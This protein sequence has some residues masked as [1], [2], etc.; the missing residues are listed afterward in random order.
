V[1]IKRYELTGYED[2]EVSDICAKLNKLGVP[3][4][5]QEKEFGKIIVIDWPSEKHLRTFYVWF[6]D[7]GQV[8]WDEE[9]TLQEIEKRYED[10]NL[11]AICG[12]LN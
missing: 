12:Q 10:F 7:N 9:F 6:V 1:L 5:T 2:G 4:G 8:V 3:F 11:E